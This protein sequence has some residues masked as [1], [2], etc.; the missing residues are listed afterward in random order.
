MLILG[1]T[2]FAKYRVS[3]SIP[4]F[5]SVKYPSVIEVHVLDGFREQFGN[6]SNVIDQVDRFIIREIYEPS[7]STIPSM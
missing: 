1:Q 3:K 4:V 6:G 2:N 5:S 7:D